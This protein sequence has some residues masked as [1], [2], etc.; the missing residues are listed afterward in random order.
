MGQVV[1]VNECPAHGVK[2]PGKG[3]EAVRGWV[4][5][6]T[7]AYPGE[8]RV[9]LFAALYGM[10]A[11]LGDLTCDVSLAALARET[12]TDRRRWSGIIDLLVSDGYLV[13]VGSK[14]KTGVYRLSKPCSDAGLA[15]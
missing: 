7:A 11:H 6:V 10:K 8:T 9:P 12:G 14:G 3:I 2:F 4:Y 1:E 5:M 15:F 13:P